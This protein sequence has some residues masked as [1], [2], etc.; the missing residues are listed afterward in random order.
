MF[1]FFFFFQMGNNFREGNRT[2]N[3]RAFE[4]SECT[5]I[6]DSFHQLQP[7]FDELKFL[8]IGSAVRVLSPLFHRVVHAKSGQELFTTGTKTVLGACS[9]LLVH[10][11]PRTV[12]ICVKWPCPGS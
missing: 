7:A 3:T 5:D 12:K 10:R 4:S 6:S 11:T 8:C 1:N 2:L 9:G